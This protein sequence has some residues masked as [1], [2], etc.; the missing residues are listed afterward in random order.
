MDRVDME[1]LE[2]RIIA[3]GRQSQEAGLRE[4]AR[5]I[6]GAPDEATRQRRKQEMIGWLY[7]ARA[8]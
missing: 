6:N 7:G 5:Y 2:A 1:R 4:A 3:A 8:A